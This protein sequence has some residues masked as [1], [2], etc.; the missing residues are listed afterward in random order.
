MLQ[1]TSVYAGLLTFV[2]LVLSA[3]VVRYRR[4]QKVSVGD[5][6]DKGM[7]KRMRAQANCAEYMPIGLILLGLIEMQG[8]PIYV[9]HGL[10]VA[11]TLGRVLHGFGFSSTPQVFWARISG[12]LLTLC[13][14]A[15]SALGLVFHG[16]F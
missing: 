2:F 11:L 16:L 13:M 9:V 12:M 4:S 14:L 3:R 8:T 10:G 15:L 6:G 7:I 1:V 5:H